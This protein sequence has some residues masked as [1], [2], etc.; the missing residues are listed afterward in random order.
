MLAVIFV[1]R[2]C[3]PVCHG[4]RDKRK[5]FGEKACFFVWQ[6]TIL[7]RVSRT[8]FKWCDRTHNLFS[9]PFNIVGLRHSLLSS[10]V[11]FR[12]RVH[13]SL[14]V[15]LSS[16]GSNTI[17]FLCEL[18]RFLPRDAIKRGLSRHAVSVCLSRSWVVSKRINLSSK[19][20]HRRVAKPF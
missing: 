13:R 7:V 10:F 20:F 1:G 8:F 14:D 17:D 5:I 9:N 18:R 19:F 6:P 11:S 12:I 4:N 15:V 2:Q 3:W 16:H